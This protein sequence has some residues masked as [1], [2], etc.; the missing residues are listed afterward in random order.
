MQAGES[1]V[2]LWQRRNWH[3][4]CV[5][6]VLRGST[7][8]LQLLWCEHSTATLCIIGQNGRLERWELFFAADVSPR[9]SAAVIDGSEVLLTPLRL[10]VMPPPLHAAKVV[11]HHA[12]CAV[13]WGDVQGCECLALAHSSGI[14]VVASVEDDLWEETAEE[15]A[16]VPGNSQ[17]NTSSNTIHS[18][19]LELPSEAQGLTDIIKSCD[20]LTWLHSELLVLI[21][22]ACVHQQDEQSVSSACV[23]LHL[24]WP[25]QDE[26]TGLWR[27]PTVTSCK[28]HMLQIPV[29]F[30]L[31][32]D[33]Q[34]MLLQDNEGKLSLVDSRGADCA[35]AS[36]P[37]LPEHCQQLLIVN[38][39]SSEHSIYQQTPHIL[40]LSGSGKL[41][42]G[43]EVLASNVNSMCL[44]QW[45]PGGRYLLVATRSQVLYCVQLDQMG[46]ALSA[47]NVTNSCN[48]F[49]AVGVS[50][51][52]L[53]APQ[54]TLSLSGAASRAIEAGAELVAVPPGTSLAVLQMPRGNLEGVHVRALTI[55]SVTENLL[56][57]RYAAAVQESAADRLDLN[58]LVDFQW[59]R[60]IDHAAEFVKQV[61]AESISDLLSALRPEIYPVKQQ[62]YDSAS[63]PADPLGIEQPANAAELGPSSTDKE[64]STK[65]KVNV[66]C[67]AVQ[68]ECVKVGGAHLRA[69]L[70]AFVRCVRL[71]SSAFAFGPLCVSCGHPVMLCVTCFLRVPVRQVHLAHQITQ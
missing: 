8:P 25:P 68:A 5:R 59:P 57:N 36:T 1:Y 10:T 21:V 6:E 55:G 33:E 39:S 3:W 11:T 66:V 18:G 27:A 32:W 28:M 35:L 62:S 43:Q 56:A 37:A 63:A 4:Y 51:G 42:C 13:A 41:F 48:F 70:M 40:G 50:N 31:P 67:Q 16:T 15:S 64:T 20:S 45:G 26:S 71:S 14:S 7:G 17:D 9:G 47:S 46:D 22:S 58:V 61:K 34:R 69:A 38:G 60:F 12:V 53:S 52:R 29:T 65:S 19:Q 44:R 30:C 2:Q 54:A 49:A 23:M 24:S